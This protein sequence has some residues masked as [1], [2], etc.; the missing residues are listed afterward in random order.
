MSC[1]GATPGNGSGC[2]FCISRGEGDF[3]LTPWLRLWD[4]TLDLQ[5]AQRLT[6]DQFKG[7]INLLMLANRQDDRGRLPDLETIAFSLRV[8]IDYAQDLVQHLVEAKLID[9]KGNATIMHDWESW[10]PKGQTNAERARAYRESCAQRALEQAHADRT[11]SAH[12]ALLAPACAPGIQEQSREEK[13]REENPPT[14]LAGGESPGGDLSPSNSP[15]KKTRKKRQPEP[16][17]TLPDWLPLEEWSEWL[18][19]RKVKRAASTGFALRLAI[20]AL[21]DLRAKGNDPAKVLRRSILK[22]YTD[23]YPLDDGYGR[24]NGQL[25]KPRPTDPDVRE[26]QRQ[27]NAARMAD[28][29]RLYP[30]E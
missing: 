27:A 1:V 3:V 5:K 25:P 29:K 12:R 4:R 11:P 21:T 7:W 15:A 16:L 18:A 8:S 28:I 13:S 14:P 26:A 22:S 19:V 17:P 24:P 23:L 6:G 2:S 30:K 9:R 20:E 10:Q